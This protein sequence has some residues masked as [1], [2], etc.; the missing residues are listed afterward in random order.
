MRILPPRLR[1]Q[2]IQP[3]H[4]PRRRRR[5]RLY[6]TAW[7]ESRDNGK[8]FENQPLSEVHGFVRDYERTVAST[9]S[10]RAIGKVARWSPN[11]RS[12]SDVLV[13]YR[14]RGVKC[15]MNSSSSIRRSTT[16]T[17]R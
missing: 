12:V 4:Q 16:T 1:Q 17:S 2:D 14:L 5:L 15:R 13:A 9:R 8:N 10:S 3:V 6:R 11:G 7:E